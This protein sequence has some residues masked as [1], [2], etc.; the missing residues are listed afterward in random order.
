MNWGGGR[1]EGN[2]VGNAEAIQSLDRRA[3]EFIAQANVEQKARDDVDVVLN[4][5]TDA[6]A[7]QAV[8]GVAAHR[9]GVVRD[10]GEQLGQR[11]GRRVLGRGPGR[12]PGGG[13]EQGLPG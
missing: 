7:A 11:T 1:E 2:E 6:V 3:V 9:E 13:P 12:G 5:S 8:V 10:A 4:V